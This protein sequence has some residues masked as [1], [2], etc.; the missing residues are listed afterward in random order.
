MERLL[1][2]S[3]WLSGCPTIRISGIFATSDAKNFIKGR[4]PNRGGERL[5]EDM[6]SACNDLVN[7]GLLEVVVDAERAPKKRGR[8]VFKYTK[9]ADDRLTEPAWQERVRL[10]LSGKPE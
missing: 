4:L 5:A 3:A 8:R 1:L 9:V 2:G 10:G 7:C 6:V